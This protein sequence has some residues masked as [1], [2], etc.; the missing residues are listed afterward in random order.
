MIEHLAPTRGRL[1][2]LWPGS[3]TLDSHGDLR[4]ASDSK[5]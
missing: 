2:T 1:M 3:R 4:H 5:L